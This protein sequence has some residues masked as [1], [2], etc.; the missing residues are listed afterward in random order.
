MDFSPFGCAERRKIRPDGKAKKLTDDTRLSVR[1][2]CSG[3]F[4]PAVAYSVAPAS[5]D[6]KRAVISGCGSRTWITCPCYRIPSGIT[7]A[8]ND[9]KNGHSSRNQGALIRRNARD[10][11]KKSTPLN[12]VPFEEKRG[13]LPVNAPRIGDYV[14]LSFS[15]SQPDDFR[16]L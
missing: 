14:A 10:D 12:D 13:A 8:C 1:V 6:E 11:S 5:T 7:R 16:K 9:E 3:A 2:V 15:S 4:H